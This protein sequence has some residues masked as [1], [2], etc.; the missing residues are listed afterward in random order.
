MISMLPFVQGEEVCT[1]SSCTDDFFYPVKFSGQ[2][3]KHSVHQNIINNNNNNKNN[4]LPM[5]L[6]F[7]SAQVKH[8]VKVDG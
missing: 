4:L 6:T 3:H 7:K 2:I 5:V 1:S 8:L